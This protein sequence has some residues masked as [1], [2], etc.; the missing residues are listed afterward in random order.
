MVNV[1]II[2]SGIRATAFCE[3]IK[4]NESKVALKALVDPEIKKAKFLNEY[5]SL[6]AET[7]KDYHE[8][9][10][11]PEIDAVI[12]ATPD[13]IHVQPAID[14][15]KAGKN[16]YIE[17]PL[18]TTIEDCD[19]IIRAFDESKAQCY[20][21]FNLRHSPVYESI[22]NIVNNGS[23]GKVATIEANEWYYGGKTYFRR[24]NRF[25]KQSGGLWLT[26]ACHDFDLITWIAGAKP[27][28]LYA[29]CG[30]SHYNPKKEAG[31]RCKLCKI[32]NACPDYYNLYEKIEGDEFN[33]LVRKMQL[34]IDQEGEM[35]PD[36]CLYNSKKDTFDNGI[37]VIDYENGIRATYTVNVLAAKTTRQMRVIGSQG[38]VES[39]M[40]EGTIK[41]TQ[42]HTEKVQTINLNGT[43]GSHFGADEKIL[44]DFFEMCKNGKVPRS[45][46]ADGKLAV[47]ISLAA[48]ESSD[49]KNIFNF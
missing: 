6:K 16:L 8:C 5:Y 36:V 17:K 39:D 32:K 42:R 2:G 41:L 14:T 12:L 43:S 11:K 29:T 10:A 25:T 40:Q 47:Q 4:K 23:L 48:K 28:S 1:L 27:K 21:G 31:P 18:A 37:A 49:K 7:H 15:L 38:M 26:K 35:A 34:L 44:D 22:Y 24:W 19:R 33:E 46:L 13:D 45:G 3:Y 9:I 30:L 20:L